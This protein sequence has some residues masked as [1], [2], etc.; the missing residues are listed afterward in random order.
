MDK[1]EGKTVVVTGASRGIGRDMALTFAA[2]G[3]KVVV[4]ARTENEGDF[5]NPWQHREDGGADRGGRRPRRSA[6]AAT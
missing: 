5:R 3:A 4:S 2:E 1:L 6:S